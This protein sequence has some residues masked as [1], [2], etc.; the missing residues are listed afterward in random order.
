[1][2]LIGYP[3]AILIVLGVVTSGAS[4]VFADWALTLLQYGV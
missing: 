2:S 3:G 4:T 1:M